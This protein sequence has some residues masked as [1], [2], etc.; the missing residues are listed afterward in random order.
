MLM[1][2][3][4]PILR[5]LC[6]ILFKIRFT[7]L[8]KIDLTKPVIIMPNHLSLL[9][10]V[11]LGLHLP[12]EVT[13][14][15]NTEI[16][17]RFGLLIKLRKHIAVNPL[18][19]YS[20]RQ[21]VR[22]VQ[23]GSPL[24][25]FPEGRIT[26]TG[27]LMKIYSGIAYIGLKT[28]AAL[29]PVAIN[30][31][32]RSK[33]SYLQDKVRTKWF[34]KVS[35]TIGDPFLL[36]LTKDKS[37]K[38]QKA[39]AADQIQQKLQVELF[40]S[41]TKKN[42]NLFNEIIVE[43]QRNG[44]GFTVCEDPTQKLTYKRLLIAA[45]IFSRKL[46]Q[47]LRAQDRVA[48]LLPNS[49][50]QVITL[51]A[52]FR[53]GKS[54]ALLNFSAGR[55]N[56]QDACETASVKT[57]I[58][59][60]QFVTKA[61]LGPV[62]EALEGTYTLLYLEDIRG[63]VHFADKLIGFIH[64]LMKQK[65]TVHNNEVVLFTSGSENKPKGVV[66]SHDNLYANVQQARTMIDFTS[67]DVVF[68][69]MPMFHSFGLTA[70]TMLPLLSGMKVYMYP[71]PL[72]YKVIPEIIYDIHATVLFGTSTFF[73]A[74]GKFA[75][76][77]DFHSLRHVIT[78][79]EKLK[80]EVRSLWADKFGIRLLE[81]YGTT[82]AAPVVTLNTPLQV[83]RGTV[84]RFLPGIEHRLE[85]VP[86]IEGGN[87][88]IKGPNLMKGYLIH[89]KGFIPCPEWYD[90]GDVV[91]VD[92]D[93]FVKLHARL[94]RFAKIGGEMVSL[95]VVEEIAMQC[96]PHASIAAIA[97]QDVRKGEKIVLYHTGVELDLQRFKEAV[98]QSGYS[99]LTIPSSLKMIEQMPLLG[100]GK[101]DYVTLKQRAEGS[102]EGVNA[103]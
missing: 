26:T 57:V 92:K 23:Q 41:R 89:G 86:G 65:A 68:N 43:G 59:S 28:G 14:V 55:Q 45:Y 75:H 84:G 72:H 21:M 8:E 58:T 61:Q 37:L 64:F 77:Y 29:Y 13:F 30:G 25:V 40:K 27:G 32:E 91:S 85:P 56:I 93:G 16:A 33:L 7:G 60:R 47:P 66:L 46:T 19:P 71:S 78:G 96:Y 24:L 90:C 88:W 18:N 11:L 20:V 103:V 6:N 97:V 100:N 42:M 39:E 101:I 49:A 15:V 102:A 34:P 53:M 52:L 69:A 83:K 98:K 95:N 80:D 76:P 74:Y 51:L 35:I 4:I 87:L 5:F 70:G 94:K 9:D 73:A 36:V 17:K 50:G 82:E 3:I 38:I 63:T 2:I 44:F 54:P 79:A 67:K 99:P 12:A 48:M 22:T 81:G 31:L 62:I 10:A 1:V